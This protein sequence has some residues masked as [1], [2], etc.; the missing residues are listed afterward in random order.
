LF[1]LFITAIDSECWRDLRRR[2]ALSARFLLS[3]LLM[4]GIKSERCNGLGFAAGFAVGFTIACG[5]PGD[6]VDMASS[7][8]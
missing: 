8:G 5:R 7:L 6:F 2:P 1:F 3:L 4:P